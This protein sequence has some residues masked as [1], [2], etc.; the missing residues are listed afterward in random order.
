MHSSI[1]LI[2]L[3]ILVTVAGIL[4]GY[5]Y[6]YQ[7]YKIRQYKTARSQSRMFV[8]IAI[9]NAMSRTAFC[10]F[11]GQYLLALIS[12]FATYFIIELFWTTYVYYP[13]RKRSQFGFKKPNI[14]VYFFN[15]L[16]PNQL[17]RRL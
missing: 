4:D 2:I 11:V 8:N 5:K 10:I 7:T 17:R 6:K 16:V 14:I 9:F 12:I 13:F 1:I 3:S 15:S